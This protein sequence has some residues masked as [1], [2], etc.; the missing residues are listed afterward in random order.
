MST[1]KSLHTCSHLHYTRRPWK[2]ALVLYL[3][4][5]N[6]D[7]SVIN[8]HVSRYVQRIQIQVLVLESRLRIQVKCYLIILYLN[9]VSRVWDKRVECRAG[10]FVFLKEQNV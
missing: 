10:N 7:R 4:S 9:V 6:I 2:Q 5:I 8:H 1:W 3:N